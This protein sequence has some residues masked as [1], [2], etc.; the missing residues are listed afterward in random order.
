M[1]VDITCQGYEEGTALHIAATNLSLEA[2]KVLIAFG[3][4]PN[5]KDDLARTPIDCIPD[6]E[7]VNA[8][9]IYDNV[10]D[11]IDRRQRIG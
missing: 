3:S 11:I 8:S 1:D 6:E 10:N 7:Q 2:A 9:T 4:D 5:L